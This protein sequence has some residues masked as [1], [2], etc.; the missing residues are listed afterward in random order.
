MRKYYTSTVQLFR[1]IKSDYMLTLTYIVPLLV[2]CVIKFGVPVLE[3]L[4]TNKFQTEFLLTPYYPLFD[5]FL[6]MIA[7]IMFCFAFA[8]ILLE[9]IDDKVARYFMITP[10]GKGGYLFS[11][12]GLPAI[13][14]LLLTPLILFLF[15]ISSMSPATLVAVSLLATII[16]MI[17]ALMV[18][19]LS[20]NKLEGMAVTK[21]AS[22]LTLGILP[23]FFIKGNTEYLFGILPSYWLGKYV[24]SGNALVFI[25]GLVVSGLW[26][27]LLIK[28]FDK[29]VS[30]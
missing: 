12:I 7:P 9:E 14:S 21:M 23:P 16:G 3:N 29:K 17:V 5:L 2:G 28:K 20:S 24:R 25:S 10:L 19:S 27:F 8:M 22:M 26:I 6:S 1:Q 30:V 15:H 11:R 4:L 13:L 18:V